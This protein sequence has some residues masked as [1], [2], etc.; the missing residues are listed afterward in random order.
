MAD[1]GEYQNLA[2]EFCLLE[3][4]A[5]ALAEQSG[6]TAYCCTGIVD[7]SE[8]GG[9]LVF[10]YL[11]DAD[12]LTDLSEPLVSE[13]TTY[14]VGSALLGETSEPESESESAETED[15]DEEEEEA[16]RAM[17][18]V[19]LATIVASVVLFGY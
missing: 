16:A 7:T 6:N 12:T 3:W 9:G 2:N 14:D 10:T 19:S 13:G 18:A 15:D 11:V 17:G 8:G 1:D 4:E 5:N